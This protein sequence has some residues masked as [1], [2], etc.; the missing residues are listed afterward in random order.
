MVAGGDADARD[1]QIIA[2]IKKVN[3]LSNKGTKSVGF[4]PETV[5][6]NKDHHAC[7]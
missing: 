4:V 2:L 3:H 6:P 1:Q 5:T 7:P